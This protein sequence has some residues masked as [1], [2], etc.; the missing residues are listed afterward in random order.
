MLPQYDVLAI[1]FRDIM[2][3]SESL[4]DSALP[5]ECAQVVAAVQVGRN[6]GK[7]APAFFP[8]MGDS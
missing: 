3:T 5:G 4:V 2:T 8:S 1:Y 6:D 7:T